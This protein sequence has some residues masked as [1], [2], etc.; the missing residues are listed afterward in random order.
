MFARS[1][2]AFRALPLIVAAAC[3]ALL[4]PAAHA[5]D[6]ALTTQAGF[7]QMTVTA[8]SADD[9]PAHFAKEK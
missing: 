8:S 3:V 5:A 9:K 7:R 2:V 1:T 4:L 6:A